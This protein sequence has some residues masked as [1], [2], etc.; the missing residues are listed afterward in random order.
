[1]PTNTHVA[2]DKVTVGSAT[3]TI[4]F[5]SIPQGYTDLV[6]VGSVIP[7]GSGLSPQSRINSDS[8]NNYSRTVL[9]GN[10]SSASSSRGSN[11]SSFYWYE[12]NSPATGSPTPYIIQFMNYSNT[13]TYK[14]IL[15][16]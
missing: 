6:M 11:N 8:G 9:A 2:L 4:T 12:N 16:R 13:S 1:M 14:T 5:T 3:N 15:G 10:G 7:S